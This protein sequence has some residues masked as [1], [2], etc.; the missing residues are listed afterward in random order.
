MDMLGVVNSIGANPIPVHPKMDENWVNAFNRTLSEHTL[1]WASEVTTPDVSK[2]GFE[3]FYHLTSREHDSLFTAPLGWK[4]K[5]KERQTTET[6]VQ[7]LAHPNLSVRFNRVVSFLSALHCNEKI[8]KDNERVSVFSEYPTEDGR[9]DIMIA[10][11]DSIREADF[12]HAVIV[13]VKQ[14]AVL[15]D[16]QLKKYEI[17]ALE[18][19]D[20]FQFA[21]LFKSFST[22]DMKQVCASD[23][24]WVCS[25]WWAFLRRMECGLQDDTDDFEFRQFRSTLWEQLT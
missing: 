13:E 3:A 21:F 10:W 17:S 20:T 8:P 18:I 7:F 15:D 23:R 5:L 6:L 11:G 14:G 12:K 9:I 19:A 16:G 22:D 24:E 4:V 25:Q 2:S 1:T